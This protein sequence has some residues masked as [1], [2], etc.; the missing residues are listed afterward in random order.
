[1][2][3]GCLSVRYQ[4]GSPQIQATFRWSTDILL[5]ALLILLQVVHY[6]GGEQYGIHL[7]CNG[8]LRRFVTVT[9]LSHNEVGI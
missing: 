3:S 2:C 9:S 1:M 4:M 7:D 5:I 8:L 6:T